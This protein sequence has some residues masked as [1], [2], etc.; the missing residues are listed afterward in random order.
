MENKFRIKVT[1]NTL[2]DGKIVEESK[3]LNQNTAEQDEDI[4]KE[5]AMQSCRNLNPGL[6]IEFT[7]IEVTEL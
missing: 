1:Y 2:S 4:A 6:D 7:E 5:R 3:I